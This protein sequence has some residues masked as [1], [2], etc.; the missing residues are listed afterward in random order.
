MSEFDY[1]YE[2]VDDNSTGDTI[3][4]IDDYYTSSLCEICVP[5]CGTQ[6]QNYVI[7]SDVK[8]NPPADVFYNLDYAL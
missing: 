3:F 6:M 4:S 8:D 2:V 5:D 7:V 1:Y